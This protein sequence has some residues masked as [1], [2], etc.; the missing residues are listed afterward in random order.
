MHSNA[1]VRE[2]PAFDRPGTIQSET[3]ARYFF[4]ATIVNLLVSAI[5]TTLVL[6]PPLALPIKLTVWP[7][8]WMFIAYFS[9]L[10]AGVMGSLAWAL[11]YHLLP[12]MLR[13]N[14]VSK[15]MTLAQ[16]LL[17]Q[18][19]VYGV[20]LLMGLVPGYTGGTLAINGFGLF[21][22]TR[23]IEWTVVP[24][25]LLVGLAIIATITGIVNI[26]FSMLPPPISK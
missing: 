22:I 5:V 24:I 9:F 15:L 14:R 26:V 8:T 10:I 1:L 19:G 20:A 25:G 17:Y 7:G 4:F 16:L 3:A 18:I 23:V 21:L 6:I 12:A 2:K 11:I 13:V